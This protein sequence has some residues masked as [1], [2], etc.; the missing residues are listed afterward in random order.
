MVGP[1]PGGRNA[2]RARERLYYFPIGD[3]KWTLDFRSRNHRCTQT[4][5]IWEIEFLT[6]D[7][8]DGD[9]A[10]VVGELVALVVLALAG[11]DDG[12]GLADRDHPRL[13]D[14]VGGTV[15]QLDPERPE[16]L[17]VELAVEVAVVHCEW[18]IAT[19][20]S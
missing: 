19:Q 10:P 5:R 18:I 14:V 4:K 7:V 2:F 17:V 16:R 12:A 6:D 11:D 1:T 3:F 13:A 8:V 15:H 9:R 20:T